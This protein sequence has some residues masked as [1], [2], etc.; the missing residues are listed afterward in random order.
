MQPLKEGLVCEYIS[1]LLFVTMNEER[2]SFSIV[3]LECLGIGVLVWSPHLHGT[4]SGRS[5]LR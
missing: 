1:V 5:E 3:L 2:M 4:R